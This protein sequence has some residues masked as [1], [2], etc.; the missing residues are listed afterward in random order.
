MTAADVEWWVSPWDGQTH[1]FR[2]RGED[3][4]QALCTHSAPT[5][6]LTTSGEGARHC[7]ACLL[8]HGSELAN[9]H[10]DANRWGD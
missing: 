6:R 2:K 5:A 1:L 7:M 8:T 10:G 4:S 3:V 9:Q